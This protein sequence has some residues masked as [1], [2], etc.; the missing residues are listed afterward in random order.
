[1]RQLMFVSAFGAGRKI[2][3]W[4]L[5]IKTARRYIGTQLWQTVAAEQGTFGITY[6]AVVRRN[7][8]Q[9]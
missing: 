6:N 2:Y 9:Y 3:A 7:K 5:A 8:S 1:M 4:R